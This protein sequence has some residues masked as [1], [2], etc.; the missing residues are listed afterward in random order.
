M[1]EKEIKK[2]ENQEK[3]TGAAQLPEYYFENDWL[4]QK[5]AEIRKAT[6]ILHG[7]S[8]AFI[9]DT[10][11]PSNAMNSKYLLQEV[12][13]QTTVKDVFFGGDSVYAF[14]TQQ[15]CL[16]QAESMIAFSNE[17]T[18]RFY[19]VHGNH[20][21][22]IRTSWEDPSGFTAQWGT[23]YDLVMRQ[24]ENAVSGKA[25]K[26]YYYLD[27]K[28][29]KVRYV[30][31]DAYE[32]AAAENQ[33]WGI[34][35]YVSQEQY[36]W[37]VQEALNV[38]DYTIIAFAHPSADPEVP[39]HSEQ[40]IPVAELLRALNN[41][42]KY[43]WKQGG[44]NVEADFTKATSVAA[45]YICG[46]NHGDYD[47]TERG[48][49]TISTTCDASYNDDPK[50]KRSL[51]DRSEQAFDVFTVDTETRTISTVRVGAGENRSWKY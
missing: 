3:K 50:C 45:A 51:G 8:F 18:D 20:D 4:E 40:M 46:H 39:S 23:V 47:H 42:E 24:R 1:A 44:L 5:M 10:H 35:D 6:R 7:V 14:G 9:T 11:V 12:V 13:R 31:L 43:S 19:N 30:I 22:T 26:C 15:E 21:F 34:S 49:L 2:M 17:V 48:L 36:D 38:Q 32:R 33:A 41:R 16:A 25:G 37:L 29:Q 27:N 28:V